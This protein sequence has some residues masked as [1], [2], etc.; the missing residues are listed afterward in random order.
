M[1][2]LAIFLLVL[3]VA[4][5]VQAGSTTTILFSDSYDRADN[6]DIDADS[7]GMAGTQAPMTYVEAFEGSGAATSIQVLSNELDVAN[8]V[9]MG[10]LYL[11]HNF[12]EA[13]ILSDDGF[14]VSLEV[15]SIN[16]AGDDFA[17]RWG[18]F[19]VG[20]TAA[21]A[22]A[23]G[24]LNDSATTLRGGG[25]ATGV[26]DFYVDI[27]QDQNLRMWNNGTLLNTI[28]IGAAAGTITVEFLVSDFNAGSSVTADVYYNGALVDTQSFTWDNTDTN[29]IGISGRTG[30][31]GV[32]LD[33]LAIA[34]FYDD[35]AQLVSPDGTELVN[36]ASGTVDL[37]WNK[38]KD[39]LGNPNADI[40]WHYVYVTEEVTDSEPNFAA[41]TA[42]FYTVAD[43]TDPVSQSITIDYD[44]MKYWRVDESVAVSGGDSGPNDPNTIK[45]DIWQFETLKSVPVVTDGPVDVMRYPY[46]HVDYEGDAVLTCTFDNINP[47]DVKWYRGSD[48]V[49]PIVS[50]GDFTIALIPADG[51]GTDSTATLTIA[52]VEAADEDAYYCEFELQSNPGTVVTSSASADL[53]VRRQVAYWTL[54]SDVSG[55]DNGLYIDSS[56]EGHHAEPNALPNASDVTHFPDGVVVA[57]TNESLNIAADLLFAADSGDWA[58]AAYT[59]ETTFSVWVNWDGS[60]GGWQGL[61]SNRLTTNAGEANYY[62]EI[63]QDNGNLQLGG[64]PGVGDLSAGALP[65]GQWT[66]V[67]FTARAGDVVIYI[68]GLA[69]ATNESGNAV[70]QNT[71][72]L[73][74][75]AL[76][77][78][79]SYPD[80]LLSPF[81]GQLDDVQIFNYAMTAKEIID[82]FYYAI[83]EKSVCLNPDGVLDDRFDIAN[84]ETGLVA[85]EEGFVGDCLVNLSDFSEFASHWLEC[86][87]YPAEPACD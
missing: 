71:V 35:R 19:G 22:A 4:V 63:R 43:T 47:V 72:P 45:G 33:N 53:G 20:L 50:G 36:P 74:I 13:S 49:N 86:G 83:Q 55:Y 21:E 12:T 3:G 70:P 16:P 23:A 11:D 60:N 85:G 68:N 39:A 27:A 46:T 54:D 80:E 7:T 57:K 51:V 82:E 10:S 42:D 52:N 5:Q 64:I 25:S 26:C 69:V 75:G 15:V 73:Y 76:S 40:H 8:G 24:D 56:N 66:H 14:S 2:K 48:P 62:M 41:S 1:K 44:Q 61:V 32:L 6:T 18:G 58:S 78:G 31:V 30:G 77:R 29:Y 34:A 81:N 37:Q 17:N 28:A 59:G 67:A 87:L 79:A 9:G 65:V 84:A 38:G